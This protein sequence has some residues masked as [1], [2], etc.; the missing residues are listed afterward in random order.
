MR[1]MDHGRMEGIKRAHAALD[2]AHT[3]TAQ[4]SGPWSGA[5]QRPEE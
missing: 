3:G 5:E 4:W 1:S 2:A